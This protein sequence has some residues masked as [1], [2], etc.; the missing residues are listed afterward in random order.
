MW[1]WLL[2]WRFCEMNIQ[3]FY[4]RCLNLRSETRIFW[5][6]IPLWET[7]K[8]EVRS[9]RLLWLLEAQGRVLWTTQKMWTNPEW[10]PKE[11]WLLKLREWEEETQAIL[12]AKT[13]LWWL[14]QKMRENNITKQK[15]R[16]MEIKLG[17]SLVES[18]CWIS[19]CDLLPIKMEIKI[20][21]Q[22]CRSEAR[23]AA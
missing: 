9:V 5:G 6:K 16:L 10:V 23:S 11:L 13:N 17:T 14:Q 1:K 8:V 2:I 7:T 18:M 4:T 19:K 20:T 15:L 3:R 21:S 12:A 22:E